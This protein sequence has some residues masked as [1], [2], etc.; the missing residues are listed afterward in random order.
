MPKRVDFLVVGSGIAGLTFATKV[1][2]L[3][4]TLILT[5]KRKADTSTNYAQGGIAAVFGEDDSLKYHAKDTLMAGEGL[6]HRKAVEIMVKQG[7]RLVMELHDMGC[8]FSTSN[9]KTFDLGKEGGH[10]KRRIVHAKDF[11]GMEIERILLE[12]AKKDGVT[13]SE[14]KIA[15]DLIIEH[16]ECRGIYYFEADTQKINALKSIFIQQ[17]RQSQQVMVLPWHIEPEQK[18]LIWN[19]FSSIRRLFII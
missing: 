14:N 12:E 3:G 18:S 6:C 16:G 5:K 15:L 4:E 13:I 8:R 19:S 17:I 10:S 9:G 1:A 11:T 2:H 7:P